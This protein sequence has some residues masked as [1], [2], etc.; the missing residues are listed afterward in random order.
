MADEDKSTNDEGAEENTN[1]ESQSQSMDEVIEQEAEKELDSERDNEN[2]D[3]D[4][5]E[6]ESSDDDADVESESK[7]SDEE[8]KSE[9]NEDDESDDDEDEEEQKQEEVD[10][11]SFKEVGL[12]ALDQLE[13]DGKE[14]K[15]T[16]WSDLLRDAVDVVR[17]EVKKEADAASQQEAE[18]RQEVDA[19]NQD[20]QSEIDEL[21]KSGDLPKDEAEV[22]KVFEYMAEHN[23][24]HSD[25][26]NKQIW[27]FEIAFERMKAKKVTDERKEEIA[28]KRKNRAAAASGR[29][30][31]DDGSGLPKVTKGMSMDDIIEQELGDA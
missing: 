6:S 9:E 21:Q 5:E 13:K 14:Y 11:S 24:K 2:G 30:G 16:S 28:N 4:S 18:F 20:W 25:N 15:P 29:G 10:T 3:T 12:D 7:E 27:S 17:G 8:D 26:D 19:V 1:E 22:K 31:E 23:K